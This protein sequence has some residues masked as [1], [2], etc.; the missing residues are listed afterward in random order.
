MELFPAKLPSNVQIV[1]VGLRCY[2]FG[3]VGWVLQNAG[4]DLTRFKYFVWLDSSVRGPFL[5]VYA[6]Q[7][8]G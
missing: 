4:L 5:P 3:T 1:R 2:N 7:V 8:R 6:S